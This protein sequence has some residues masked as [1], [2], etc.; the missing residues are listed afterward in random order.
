MEASFRASGTQVIGLDGVEE[1]VETYE[2]RGFVDCARIPLMMRG[3]L[4][5]KPLTAFP[6]SHNQTEMMED[7]KCVDAQLLAE[8]DLQHTGLD[9]S[10]YWTTGALLSREDAY[11]Y[12][13]CSASTITG[14]ILVRRCEHGHRFGPLYGQTSSQAQQLLHKAMSDLAESDGSLVAEIF[15]PNS[16]GMNVFESLG[17]TYAGVSYHRMWLHGKVP[18]EQREGGKGQKGMF[19]IFDAGAG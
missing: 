16:E 10:A 8:L 6:A 18:D 14:F 13:S 7:I 9:R 12:A 2:R 11:G 1:Q 19:A 15:G 3:P 17:W 4:R 5:T